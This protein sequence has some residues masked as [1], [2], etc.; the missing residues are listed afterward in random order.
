MGDKNV[1]DPVKNVKSLYAICIAITTSANTEHIMLSHSSFH[2]PYQLATAKH[3]KNSYI[4]IGTRRQNRLGGDETT[5]SSWK[6]RNLR[7]M[8]SAVFRLQVYVFAKNQIQKLRD[9]PEHFWN[10]LRLIPRLFHSEVS[11]LHFPQI[12]NF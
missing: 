6:L 10:V 11:L 8:V 7:E 12:G 3:T 5:L 9:F 2:L 4:T 1:T